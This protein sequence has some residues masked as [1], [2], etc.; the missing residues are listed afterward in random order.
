M[1]QL[2]TMMMHNLFANIRYIFCLPTIDALK[3]PFY[4]LY[5]FLRMINLL[6]EVNYKTLTQIKNL[7]IHSLIRLF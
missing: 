4:F 3:K 2:P 7:L 5:C 6:G 1:T